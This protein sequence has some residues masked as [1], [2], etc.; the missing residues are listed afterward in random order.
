MILHPTLSLRDT[1]INLNRL[2]KTVIKIG[3]I[4]NQNISSLVTI[5]NAEFKDG[6]DYI[7]EF[8]IKSYLKEINISI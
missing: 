4:N 1:P 5:D 7:L 8:P 6:Q 3:T 2:S